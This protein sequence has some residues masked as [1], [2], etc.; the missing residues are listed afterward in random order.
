MRSRFVT[1]TLLMGL[2][3][4]GVGVGIVRADGT[5]AFR[6]DWTGKSDATGLPTTWDGSANIVWKQELPGPGTSS[7]IVVNDRVYLTC[8][9][10]YAESIDNPGNKEDLV[11]HVVWLDRKSG[12]IL[13]TRPFKA[14]M[15]E[16]NYEPGN[17]SK[18]GYASSTLTTDG[19]R[20]YAFFGI[21]GV[22]CL[23]LD[24]NEIWS[25][26]VGTGTHGWGSATSPLLH[27]NLLVVNASIESQSM[28]ALDKMTGKEVW[29][30]EGIN[31]CWAS[32]VLV[33]AGEGKQEIVLNVPKR[34]TGYDPDSGEELWFCEGIPDG[35]ICPTAIA[36]G[37]VTYAVGGRKNTTIAVRA[38][39]RGDVNQTHVLWRTGKGSNVCSPVCLD[40]YLYLMN[41]KGTAIC[42]NAANGEVVYEE[43]LEPKPDLI[44]ASIL[45]ADGKL[46]GLS[47]EDG[48]YVL[49]AG[50][51]FKQ[52]A[53]NTLGDD[54]S[55]AN[56]C[57]IVSD[58]QILLRTDKAIYCIGK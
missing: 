35:Y 48:T 10:G 20:I 46:Y 57:P 28:I 56:A 13:G 22:Y 34:L 31:S 16:S 18:H 38:G 2:L 43:R 1:S 6:G 12:K 21:S 25:A 41:E 14:K 58:G 19:E 40:G 30:A 36:E 44:Y 8:Y 27:K 47:R 15:P 26:D 32:P 45:A 50:P 3:A 24:G 55:R 42:L 39:G 53:V 37:N 7:P 51:E 9:T 11:R 4:L 17:N 49:A 52:L 33:D 54:S 5:V 29:R 23:D